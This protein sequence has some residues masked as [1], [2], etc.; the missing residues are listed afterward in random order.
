LISVLQAGESLLVHKAPVYTTT[1]VSLDTMGI[2]TIALDY[3]NLEKL[4]EELAALP[5]KPNAALIQLTRQK[6]DDSYAFEAVIQAIKQ[7][8]PKMPIITDDN[9]AAFKLPR[10]GCQAGA[11]LSAFSTFK[12]L[13]PE[14]VGLVLGKKELI[15]KIHKYQYSGGSQVQGHEAMA[16]L[17]GMVYAPVALAIQAQVCEEIVRRI[18]GGELP[19]VKQAF[20]ANAQ[21]KVV[22]LEFEQEIASKILEITPSLGASAHPVG[23]ESIYEITP[24]I[25]RISGTFREYDPAL[26]KRMIRINPMRSG[27]DTV[28]RILREALQELG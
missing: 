4:K 8:C 20:I 6:I 21:S 23:S 1:K 7:V 16:A 22:L 15:E 13:G 27:A 24:M 28:I 25:Y 26:E 5:K 17:R 14:G 19:G 18:N 11:D 12:T 2:Q 9:Y 3:N 10:I